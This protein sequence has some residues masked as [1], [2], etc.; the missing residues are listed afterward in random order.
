MDKIGELILQDEGYSD[1]VES[2][3]STSVV[4][5]RVLED[6]TYRDVYIGTS[7]DFIDDIDFIKVEK[8]LEEK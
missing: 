1:R 3:K 5:I 4:R 2:I 7:Q 6:G 8:R